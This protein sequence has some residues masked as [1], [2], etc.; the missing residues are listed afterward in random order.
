V[1]DPAARLAAVRPDVPVSLAGAVLVESWSN[2]TWVTER[3]VLR[4]CWRG[5]R[6]RLLR[7]QALLA[8]IPGS[9]P[10]AEVLGAGQAGDLT[11][12]AL[13]RIPGQRL[14]LVWPRL[15]DD[16]RRAALRHLGAVLAALH[17]WAPPPAVRA[18]MQQAVPATP[19]AIGGSAIVPLPVT[20]LA[21][22]LDRVGQLPGMDAGLARRRLGALQGVL[23]ERE[24]TDGPVVHGD[25]HLANVLWQDGHLTA[26]LDFEWAR[27]GPPDLELEAACRDDPD[28]EAGSRH[29]PCDARGVLVL[30]G[31][32]PVIPA[33]S[34]ART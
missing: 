1:S 25:A 3:S 13:R 8:A 32:R 15:T 6:G 33:C 16:Q 10:H 28:I 31:L 20:A 23:L 12:M 34:P 22:L 14:D 26:L 21:P 4:V 19:E 17:Q 29:R 2:D 27:I 9:V 30:A 11:W 18:M 24:L 7:E 5:D